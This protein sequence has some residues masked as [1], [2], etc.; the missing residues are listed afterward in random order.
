MMLL[1]SLFIPIN[2]VCP[3]VFEFSIQYTA[4]LNEHFLPFWRYKL[5]CLPVLL[6]SPQQTTDVC[7]G[8][9]GGDQ[10]EDM[11]AGWPHLPVHTYQVPFHKPKLKEKKKNIILRQ[12]QAAN[13]K[14]NYTGQMLVICRGLL[15]YLNKLSY[16]VIGEDSSPRITLSHYLKH[17]LPQMP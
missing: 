4:S 12:M 11:Y 8:G 14:A 10:T 5:C 7:V 3:Q 13:E 6:L 2:T 17:T 16:G 15:R 1:V 9:G